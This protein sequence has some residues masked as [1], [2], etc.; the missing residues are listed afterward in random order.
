MR[1]QERQRPPC[2]RRSRHYCRN[3]RKFLYTD[4]R[5]L[6]KR[7]VESTPSILCTYSVRNPQSDSFVLLYEIPP[8]A[9]APECR[10]DPPR[11]Q[12]VCSKAAKSLLPVPQRPRSSHNQRMVNI[13]RTRPRRPR[14]PGPA[15]SDTV[16]SRIM[17]IP[18]ALY[19]EDAPV[20]PLIT[21]TY[22]TQLY[23]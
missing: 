9:P 15:Y 4:W 13:F 3:T 23:T 11:A 6:E 17:Q 19:L 8:R 21:R 16:R 1:G 12:R 10:D 2:F 20:G 22:S 5:N 18:P 14:G 7:S